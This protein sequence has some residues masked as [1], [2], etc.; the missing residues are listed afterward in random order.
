MSTGHDSAVPSACPRTDAVERSSAHQSFS[1]VLVGGRLA[2]LMLNHAE[3]STHRETQRLALITITYLFKWSQQHTCVNNPFP[4]PSHNSIHVP[5]VHLSASLWSLERLPDPLLCNTRSL[6][7][8]NV[9]RILVLLKQAHQQGLSSVPTCS[10]SLVLSYITL[11]L[12]LYSVKAA[13]TP[14]AP[15]AVATCSASRSP[16]LFFPFSSFVSHSVLVKSGLR[17][18]NSS[19]V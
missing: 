12:S 6:L 18:A 7:C 1:P 14:S 3:S 10:A 4:R 2:P 17:Y 8:G 15:A 16:L 13:P 11:P 9:N 19:C 5:Q